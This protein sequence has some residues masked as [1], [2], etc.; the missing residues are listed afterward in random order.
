MKERYS[1]EPDLNQ[2][3][4]AITDSLQSPALPTEL[5]VFSNMQCLFS[6]LQVN[7]AG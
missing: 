4:S 1:T 6:N 7:R 5:S 2:R 3:I